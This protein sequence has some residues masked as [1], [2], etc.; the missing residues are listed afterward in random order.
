MAKN[1]HRINNF[2]DLPAD[3]SPAQMQAKAATLYDEFVLDMEAQKSSIF[4]TELALTMAIGALL[5]THTTTDRDYEIAIRRIISNSE[6]YTEITRK[7]FAITE[8][9]AKSVVLPLRH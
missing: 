6:L 2:H 1:G 4:V 8:A 7:S 3:M 9:E 5:G